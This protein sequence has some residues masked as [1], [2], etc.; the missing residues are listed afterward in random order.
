MTPWVEKANIITEFSVYSKLN[1]KQGIRRGKTPV[2]FGKKNGFISM[3]KFLICYVL[4]RWPVAKTGLLGFNL[5][6]LFSTA[7]CI[8]QFTASIT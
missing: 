6:G 4:K 8:K 3:L 1:Q 5:N 7:S 2:C